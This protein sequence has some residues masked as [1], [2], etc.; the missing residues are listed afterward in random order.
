[1]KIK[2]KKVKAG[3]TQHLVIGKEYE[4]SEA[5]AKI[6]ISNG[7]AEKPGS[8]REVKTEQNK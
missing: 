6:L 5:K 1:M 2:G 7:Q 3:K 4:M 8:V